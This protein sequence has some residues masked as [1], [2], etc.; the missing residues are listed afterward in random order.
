MSNDCQEHMIARNIR[1][2]GNEGAHVH[3]VDGCRVMKLH[4]DKDFTK[5]ELKR[6]ELI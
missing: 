5:V 6:S 1:V 3:H 4:V 2:G